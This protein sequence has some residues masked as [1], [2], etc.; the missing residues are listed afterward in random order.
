[1]HTSIK[2]DLDSVER[3]RKLVAALDPVN[4]SNIATYALSLA[5]FS[6]A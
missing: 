4:T 2:T 6:L 3:F 5:R 1:M